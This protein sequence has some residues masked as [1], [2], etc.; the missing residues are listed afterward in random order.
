MQLKVNKRLASISS[1]ALNHSIDTESD[2]DTDDMEADKDRLLLTSSMTGS[3]NIEGYPFHDIAKLRLGPDFA[4]DSSDNEDDSSVGS[5]SKSSSKKKRN[6]K[7]NSKTNGDL[8]VLSK[9]TN[10]D[11]ASDLTSDLTK[12]P[13]EL[14]GT[15]GSLLG[16]TRNSDGHSDGASTLSGDD[17][18]NQSIGSG[19]LTLTANTPMSPTAPTPIANGALIEDF[20]TVD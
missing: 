16:V 5:A 14:G 15:D 3:I 11:S 6:S 8:G 7:S 13:E 12:R 20:T 17:K 2:Y 10:S 19:E 4:A 1:L 18:D 9:V